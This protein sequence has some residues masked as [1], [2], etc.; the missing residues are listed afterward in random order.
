MEKIYDNIFK[1]MVTKNPHLLIPL[2]NVAFDEKYDSNEKVVL[3]SDEHQT[4]KIDDKD[5]SEVVT[6]SYISIAGNNYHMECQSNPDGT[7]MFRMVEYDFH[8]ALD[9][10]LKNDSEIISFPRSAVLYLRHNKNTKDVMKLQIQFPGD[11]SVD[12]YVR[13]I[14]AK[15]YTKEDIIQKKLYFLVPYYIMRVEDE[16]LQKVLDDYIDLLY[17]IR[18][19]RE[20]GFLI[21][22]DLA[23][24]GKCLNKL[25]DVVY[26]KEP[27]I[28][29]GVESVMGGKV[30]YDEIDRIFDEGVKFGEERGK[31]QGIEQGIEQGEIHS[32]KNLMSNMKI[33]ATEALKN[34]GIPEEKWD[35]YI[36]KLNS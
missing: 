21:E 9:D 16:P 15:N 26:S 32:I 13:I 28:K 10:A 24:I 23:T 27:A 8:I 5:D 17:A 36:K 35:D 7:I 6:D 3:L 12:Y 33:S 34:L 4:E 1:T 11:Q 14:K 18:A 31:A 25:V 2:I 19:D 20:K 30:I 29:E 22:Y